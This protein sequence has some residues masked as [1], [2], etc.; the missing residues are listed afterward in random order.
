MIKNGNKFQLKVTV[1][2]NH[3]EYWNGIVTNKMRISCVGFGRVILE[4][5]FYYDLVLVY[6]LYYQGVHLLPSK[7]KGKIEINSLILLVPYQS[8]THSPGD[9]SKLHGKFNYL[10]ER[11]SNEFINKILRLHWIDQFLSPMEIC[12]KLLMCMFVHTWETNIYLCCLTK[13]INFT[14][15][16]HLSLMF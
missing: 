14:G 13:L 16:H 7:T 1:L 6:W 3:R 12:R 10:V 8:Q 5:L 11:N 4:V 2:K 15:I 9:H